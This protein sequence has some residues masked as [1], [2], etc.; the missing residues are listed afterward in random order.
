MNLTPSNHAG[1]QKT[2]A[3][4]GKNNRSLNFQ[5]LTV[6]VADSSENFLTIIVGI[7]R[8][9]KFSN[10]HRAGNGKEAFEL[11]KSRPID[12][13]FLDCFLADMDGFEIIFKVRHT[14]GLNQMIPM[15][16]LTS[17]TQES[18]VIRARDC[19][20]NMVIA[21]PIAG[22][23]LFDRLLWASNNAEDF[24][25]A[26]HYTGPDRRH[27]DEGCPNG[28]GRRESDKASAGEQAEQK[29]SQ[30]EIDALFK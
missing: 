17:H 20:A 26:N 16:I 4:I 21:K 11:L 30:D 19:G 25:V 14:P 12:I 23:I 18:N 5:G 1:A 2:P 22:S 28:V 29:L 13:A 27:K 9:F 8:E 7:L 15:L 10:I 24:V 6:L 3:T